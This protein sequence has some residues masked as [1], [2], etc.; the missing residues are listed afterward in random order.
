MSND[1]I[2]KIENLDN[3]SKHEIF[4]FLRNLV[5]SDPLIRFTLS[6]TTLLVDYSTIQ[7]TGRLHSLVDSFYYKVPVV[8]TQENKL[9]KEFFDIP[10][11]GFDE[12]Y[13]TPPLRTVP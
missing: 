3:T 9:E 12:V 11:R 2:T 8:S 1:I 4:L 13:H 6:G 5:A 7:E 10:I